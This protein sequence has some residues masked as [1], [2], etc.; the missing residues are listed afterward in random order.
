M[1]DRRRQR[2]SPGRYLAP[3]A[4]LAVVAGIYLIVHD[5]LPKTTRPSAA[6]Q[7]R[8]QSTRPVA[9]PPRKH[10]SGAPVTVKYYV[11]KAGDNLDLI[12]QRT[13][14]SVATIEALNRGISVNALRVGQ[15]LTLR[16]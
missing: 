16:R 6:V 3:L 1:A 10:A 7:T 15:R 14:V 4:L 13:G 12:A 8:R 5:A 9:P 11:V 2:R